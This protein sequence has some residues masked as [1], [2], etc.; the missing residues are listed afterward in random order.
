MNELE[1]VSA[2]LA[3]AIR[4]GTPL[5]YAT[6]GEL[7]TERAGVLN[8]GVEGMMMCG[9]LTAFAASLFLDPW[10]A[11]LLG[12]LAGAALAG[13]HAVVCLG[14]LGNQVV[15][16]LA[17][18][19][20]G[21]GLANYL[22]A[23]LA[24]STTQGFTQ[25]PIPYLADLPFLG[26]IL[27]RHDPLVYLSFALAPLIWL[28]LART[29]P[30]LRLRAAGE[31]PGAALAAGADVLR[32]RLWATLTGGFLSG[33]GGAYLSL[34]YA[35]QWTSGLAAGRGWIAVALVIFAFWRPGRAVLGAY[36]FGGVM[37]LQFLLQAYGVS[38]PSSLLHMLPYLMTGL[39]LTLA[40]WR[41]RRLASGGRGGGS[42][43]SRSGGVDAPAALGETLEPED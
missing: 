15:S 13:L 3:A 11:F 25:L 7:I 10:T 16:G 42:G 6:L 35:R 5:L 19:I 28:V 22:G 40:A 23:P 31:N 20:F 41:E 21:A 43:G 1:A 18:T 39:A 33:L 34:A 9:A 32:L 30:G 27:F 4:T 2:L 37:A 17:L 24:G 29:T 38:V 14:F 8:L 12:G 36:L 26:Q